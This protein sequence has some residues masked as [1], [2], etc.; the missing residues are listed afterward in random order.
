M[1]SEEGPPRPALRPANF[2]ENAGAPPI[3]LLPNHRSESLPFPFQKGAKKAEIT[4]PFA[5][6]RLPVAL[7]NIQNPQIFTLNEQPTQIHLWD[8]HY[9]TV[10][11]VCESAKHDA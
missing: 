9:L 2:D 10:L 4:K 7:H 5:M 3:A 11:S 1:L 8:R 6:R